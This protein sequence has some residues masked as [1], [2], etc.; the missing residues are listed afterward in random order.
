M[1]EKIKTTVKFTGVPVTQRKTITNQDFDRKGQ[2]AGTATSAATFVVRFW[3]E[4]TAGEVRW[5]GCIEHVQ[6]GKS[7]AFLEINGM[8]NFLQ[9]FGITVGDL[10]QLAREEA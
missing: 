2:L 8:L 5:R 10:N 9:S 3:R 7:A 6:S 4:S 1:P